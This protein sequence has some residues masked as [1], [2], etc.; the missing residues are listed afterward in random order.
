MVQISEVAK[1]IYE[2]KPERKELENF[3]LC[4][5]YLIL[6]DNTALVE[7]GCPIQ[8]PDILEAVGQL[9]YDIKKLSY[10]IPTLF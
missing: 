5:A 10:I 1:R 3:P 7:V 2:I 9:G 6:D 4:T 8:V